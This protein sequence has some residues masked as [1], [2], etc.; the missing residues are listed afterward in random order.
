MSSLSSEPMWWVEKPY[1][2][3]K[4]RG[5]IWWALAA[6]SQVFCCSF[7]LTQHL[8]CLLPLLSTTFTYICSKFRQWPLSQADLI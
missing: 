7:P 1:L 5:D 8:G 3:D 2:R 4:G 6:I